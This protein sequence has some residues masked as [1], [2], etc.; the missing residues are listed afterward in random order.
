MQLP[1]QVDAHCKHGDL[2]EDIER[3]HRS[4]LCTQTAALHF[5]LHP[6]AGQIASESGQEDG[7]HR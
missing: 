1:D 5:K 4:P 6:W 7:D 2:G 3:C